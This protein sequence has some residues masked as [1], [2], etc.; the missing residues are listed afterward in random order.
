MEVLPTKP[1]PWSEP[2]F[3][4]KFPHFAAAWP[5]LVFPFRG[6]YLCP[7]MRNPGHITLFLLTI[8]TFQHAVAQQKI[9][10][11]GHRGC[12]GLMPEN[13]MPAFFK[14]VELGVNTL[15][16]DVVISKDDQVVVSHEPWMS[17]EICSHPDG[18]PV[19]E[20]EEKSLN[21]YN[22]T[23]DEI[24]LYDCGSRGLPE[25]PIQ[26]HV[27][28][29]K[30]TLKMV[31]RSVEQF[32]VQNKYKEPRYNIEIKSDPKEYNIYSPEPKKFVEMV[33]SEI[34]RLGMMNMVTV[35]SF[36][37]NVLEELHQ[38]ADH[39]FDISYLV[40][41]GKNV[42]KNLNKLKF[43]PE[44]YSPDYKT[45]TE[46]SIHLAHALGIKVIPWTVNTREEI[47][48]LIGWGVDGIIT[49]YPDLAGAIA[50]PMK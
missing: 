25:F 7:L 35:Q 50:K 10:W 14:A 37:L 29:V 33:L 1:S 23:Y 22:M 47:D 48:K 8:V 3:L 12:R 24:Q 15:E 43:K 36:D 2:I 32:A 11:Q 45:L 18:S 39:R 31:M 28:T 20:E 5:L 40:E 21:L 16:L 4:L 26:E 6:D 17:S 13:T 42:K 46:A 30:P 9:D 44:I 34:Q 27:K 38:K 41:N 49:D 19:K